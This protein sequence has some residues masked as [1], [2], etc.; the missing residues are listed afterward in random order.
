MIEVFSA[1]RLERNLQSDQDSPTAQSTSTPPEVHGGQES[2]EALRMMPTPPPQHQYEAMQT[3]ETVKEPVPTAPEGVPNPGS[4]VTS[5][6]SSTE[7]SMESHEQ[8][9]TPP[10][11]GVGAAVSSA[12]STADMA[13]LSDTPSVNFLSPPLDPQSE[14]GQPSSDSSKTSPPPTTAMPAPVARIKG[15]KTPDYGGSAVP[16]GLAATGPASGGVGA[17]PG[18]SDTAVSTP[19]RSTGGEAGRTGSGLNGVDGKIKCGRWNFPWEFLLRYNNSSF[20]RH[21][22]M[23]EAVLHLILDALV[24]DMVC[25]I[26][27]CFC[28]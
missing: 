10:S 28:A 23:W 20:L 12:S 22:V 6:K 7:T 16:A 17:L 25:S 5:T 21:D 9:L 8:R 15:R 24:Q 27:M 1:F 11:T 18:I 19:Q 14:A 2:E 26:L 3:D 13:S 4:I